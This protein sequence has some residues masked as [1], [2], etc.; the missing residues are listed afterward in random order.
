MLRLSSNMV[1]NS[2]DESNFTHKFLLADN[3]VGMIRKVFTKNSWTDIM[4]SKTQLFKM[5]QSGEFR[6]RHL[7]PLSKNRFATNGKFNSAIG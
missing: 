4:L 7:G 5:I 3:Q 1:G 6:G 2:N